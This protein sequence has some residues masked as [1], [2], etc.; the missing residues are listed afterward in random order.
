[1]RPI[2]RYLSTKIKASDIKATDGT[3]KK[4]VKDELDRLGHDADLNHIDVSEVTNMDSLFSCYAGDLG[5]KYEDLNPDISDWNVSNIKDM[6]YMF[7]GCNKFNKDISNWDVRNV[8][9]MW[10]MF[11][12]CENFNQD[13]SQWDVNNAKDMNAMFACC[14]NFNGDISN[15]DVSKVKNM[16]AMF[17]NCENF[18]QDLS[19]WDVSNVD[20]HNFMFNNCP[21]KEE[22]KPKFKK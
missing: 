16:V 10:A 19:G 8:E 3:I 17:E 6:R 21:I 13:L 18:N 7:W 4:I 14:K 2:N 1:M 9:N 15:W 20:R 11:C 22:F 12:E 5:S